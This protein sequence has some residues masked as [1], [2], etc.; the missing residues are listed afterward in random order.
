MRGRPDVADTWARRSL[1][2]AGA[3]RPHPVA[4][5]TLGTAALYAGRL[6]EAIEHFTLAAT[7]TTLTRWRS[8]YLSTAGLAAGYAGDASRAADLT[9]TG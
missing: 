7:V 2:L 8:M 1:E 3:D 4:L 9:P 5:D 6:D